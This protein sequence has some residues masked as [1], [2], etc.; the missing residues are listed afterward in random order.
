[1]R[2][3]KQI[4]EAATTAFFSAC[5]DVRMQAR[6]RSQVWRVWACDEGHWFRS[7]G[8][9]AR[10]RVGSAVALVVL[11]GHFFVGLEIAPEFCYAAV[12]IVVLHVH[13]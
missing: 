13:R 11:A 9:V 5:C 2:D 3:G 12:G 1:M 10:I 7:R 6:A 8:A 4:A